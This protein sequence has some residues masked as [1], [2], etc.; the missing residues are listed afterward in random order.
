MIVVRGFP[1]KEEGLIYFRSIIRKRQVYQTLK[2]LEYVNFVASSTNYRKVIEDKEYLDYLR[3]FMKNYSPYYTSTIPADELPP[4][5]ELIAKS[6]KTEEPEE[7]GKFVL[8]QPVAPVD[9]ASQ[10]AAKYEGPFNPEAGKENLYALVFQPAESDIA[11]LSDSFRAFND[12]N[13]N[14][15]TL[16]VS[17]TPLDDFRSILLVSGSGELSSALLYFKKLNEDPSVLASLKK[18][19]Y[20]HFIISPANLEVLKKDKNLKSYLDFF[21]LIYK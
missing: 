17:I 5:S 7:K 16:K 1:N 11:I 4:P 12:K 20:R 19:S 9:P 14:T 13:F 21:N 6:R 10:P 15:S 8:I 18:E 2:D 3:F